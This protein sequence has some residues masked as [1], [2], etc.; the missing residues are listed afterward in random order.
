LKNKVADMPTRPPVTDW[1]SDFDHLDPAWVDNPY[2]IWDELRQKCPIAHTDRFMGVYFVSRH[3]D[4]RAV[5]LDTEHFSSRR[6]IAIREGRPPVMPAPPITSDPPVH[7]AQ[8]KLLLPAFAPEAIRRYEPQ[9][10]AICRELLEHIAARSSC[11]GAIDYAQ[12]IPVRVIATMLGV[13]PQS[14]DL[15]RRWIHE[16]FELGITDQNVMKR[17]VAEIRA[18]FAAEI[19]ERRKMPR[20]D[21]ISFLAEARIAGRK[22]DDEYITGTLRLLLI[23]GIDTTWSMIGSCLWH[24]ANHPD[25]R[26]RL[27]AEPALIP[28]AVEE[29]LRA[30]APATLAREIV[31]ETEINGCHFKEG[32]MVM[33]SF[34]A[35]NRDP[36]MFP[37]AGRVV[38]DRS[39]NR[40]A[41]FGLGIHRCLGSHLARM[42]ITVALHEW[43]AKIPDFVMVPGAKV[44]WSAGPVRGPRTLPLVFGADRSVLKPGR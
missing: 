39:P 16:F 22:L 18:F 7:S 19:A 40:H 30:Y 29:F 31:K 13:P 12:E 4:V 24:L 20:E 36:A 33:L 6:S 37:D 21:L 35:A 42:E 9:T 26:K 14:G 23:A 1:V 10:R 28:T 38:L 44:K 3:E 8:K 34:P 15:F 25:D 41:A 43:L 5:A 17:A 27:V 2:P 11:D 32:E